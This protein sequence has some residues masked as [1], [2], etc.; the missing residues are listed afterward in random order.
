M[1]S[2]SATIDATLLRPFVEVA[3]R[4]SVTAAAEALGLPGAPLRP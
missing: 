1:V 3:R 4:L 2:D